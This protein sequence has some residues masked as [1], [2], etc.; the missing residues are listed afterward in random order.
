MGT[1][2]I[3]WASKTLNYYSWNCNLVSPGCAHCYAKAMATEKGLSFDGAPRWRDSAYREYKALKAGDVAFVNSMSDTFHEAVP[4]AWLHRIFQY[5]RMRPDVKFLLLTKRIERVVYLAPYLDWSPNVW[6]GTSVESV[7]YAWRLDWLRRVP[8]AGRFV[9]FEPLLESV[10][11]VDLT[12]IDWAIVGG[13]SGDKRRAFDPEWAREIRQ[14]CRLF[15]AAFFYKQGSRL[16]PGKDDL[17]DG[18]EWKEVPPALRGRM[19]TVMTGRVGVKDKDALDITVMSANT[20][21][22]KLFAPTWE[23][24]NGVKDGTLT[25][26]AY[27]VSYLTLLRD[28]YQRD[29]AAFHRLLERDRIVLTCYCATGAFCHRH[30]ALDVIRKIAAQRKIIVVGVGEVKASATN[31]EQPTLFDLPPEKRV[32]YG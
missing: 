2:T 10:G 15:N 11:T 8:S 22:G 16:R 6:I 14:Q 32:I 7:D 28:R 27:T 29:A 4:V 24:V 18:Q 5:A 17:L 13:E 26:A 23:M 30:I 31:V 20:P 9:S 21:E 19:I 1:T 3:S 25:H 12:G